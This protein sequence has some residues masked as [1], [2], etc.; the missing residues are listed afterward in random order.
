M[1]V[2]VTGGTGFIGQKL[3]K[4]L[5]DTNINVVAA[6]RSEKNSLPKRIQQVKINDVFELDKTQILHDVDVVIHCA[7]RAH[8]LHEYADDPLTKFRQVNTEGTLT[9]ARQAVA[10]RVKRFVFISTVGVLGNS[11]TQPFTEVDK[12]N[13]QGAYAVSKYEAELGLLNLAENSN[14]EVV[15][16]RPPLVYGANAPGNFSVLLNWVSKNIWLPFGRINNKRSFVYVDNLIDL[17]LKCIKHPNAKNEIFLVSDN[18]D[19][20]TTELLARVYNAFGKGAKLLSVNERFLVA[21]FMIL[22]KKEWAVRLCGSLQID[23]SKANK[24]LGWKPPISTDEGLRETTRCF[25][26]KKLY[27]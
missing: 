5:I 9:L 6:V 23:T 20:S 3:I 1:K 4:D 27:L 22:R 2:L 16:I 13:P 12:P 25:I 8:V 17:I 11:N 7:G 18:E 15:I 26:N 24:L 19:M 21:I 14:L 10:L